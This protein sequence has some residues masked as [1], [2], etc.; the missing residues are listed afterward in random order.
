MYI[1]HVFP[2]FLIHNHAACWTMIN[3][4]YKC[5]PSFLGRLYHLPWFKHQPAMGIR[6]GGFTI[7]MWK[8]HNIAIYCN[9]R[10]Y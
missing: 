8:K 9:Y 4:R 1:M 5:L 2:M 6:M 3:P 10:I 7:N